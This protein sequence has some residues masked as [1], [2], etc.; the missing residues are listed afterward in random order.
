M[1]SRSAARVSLESETCVTRPKWHEFRSA[2]RSYAHFPDTRAALEQMV[3]LRRGAVLRGTDASAMKIGGKE[4]SIL[5]AHI[6]WEMSRHFR[7]ND[8]FRGIRFRGRA[9]D[10]DTSIERRCTARPSGI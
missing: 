6:A 8:F 10:R 7:I 9:S 3:R 1:P 4:G 2:S 5:Y